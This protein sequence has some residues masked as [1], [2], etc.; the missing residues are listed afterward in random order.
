VKNRYIE[1]TL[2]SFLNEEGLREE[3]DLRA[4]KKILADQILRIIVG[5]QRAR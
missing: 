1:S 3:V 5:L 2:S 4:K